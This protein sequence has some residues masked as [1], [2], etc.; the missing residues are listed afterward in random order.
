LREVVRRADIAKE[1]ATGGS[2][3]SCEW[4]KLAEADESSADSW[5]VRRPTKNV[6]LPGEEMERRK[7]P[8]GSKKKGR[9]RWTRED[10]AKIWVLL[11]KKGK[12]WRSIGAV[13]KFGF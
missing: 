4:E 5:H 12:A 11:R 13:K 8:C 1:L 6:I 9:G 10:V 7:V 2:Q 3:S